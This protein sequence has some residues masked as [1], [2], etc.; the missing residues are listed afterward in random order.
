MEQAPLYRQLAHHYLDA[1]EA[2]TLL[3]GDRMPSVRALMQR[4]DVSL[5]TALEACRYLESRGAVEARPR[6]GYFV[7]ARKH[8]AAPA[9]EPVAGLPDPAQYVGIHERVSNIIAAGHQARAAFDFAGATAAPEMY[10]AEALQKAAMGILRRNP[11]MFGHAVPFDGDPHFRAVLARRAL[12]C[13]IKL[14]PDDII[15]TNGCI[16]ALNLALRAVTQPGDTVAVESPTFFGLLQVLESLGLRAL[17]IPN[18]PQTGISLEAL[19][20]AAQ[21]YGN[22][23]ALVVVPTFQNPHCSVMPDAHK[24]RLVAWCE[25]Q[26]IVLIE[27]DTYAESGPGDTPPAALKSWDRDGSIIHCASLH[28]IMAPGTRL[29][30]IAPGKWFARVA[31]LKYSQTRSNEALM[32]IAAGELMGSS[33]YDR[34]LRRLRTHLRNQREN[35]A[36]A[37]AAYFPTSTRLSIPQGGMT[38]WLELPDGRSSETLFHQALGEGIR[39][40]P[41]LMYSN[42]RR[43]EHFIRLNCGATHTRES[44]QALRRL[45]ALAEAVPGSP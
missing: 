29:G 42:S 20:L 7:R 19:E 44:D 30:W 31:M 21:T 45:G 43:F 5:S 6:S 16:E 22:I 35:M 39:I 1:I 33:A 10:P 11:A 28:K 36:S 37:I 3:P 40:S 14:G 17:E 23:K 34:H 41:G 27:D 9:S 8:A 2:Y 32:Q 13:G 24:E 26:G 38:L 18:S 4:H 12:N 25:A 15:I